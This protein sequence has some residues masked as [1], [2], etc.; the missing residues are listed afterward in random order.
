[1]EA[2]EEF[3]RQQTVQQSAP[4]DNHPTIPYQLMGYQHVQVFEKG[5]YLK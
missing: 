3:L 2:V 5:I 1:M 4:Y